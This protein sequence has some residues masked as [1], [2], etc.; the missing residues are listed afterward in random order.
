MRF[1]S[2]F[3]LVHSLLGIYYCVFFVLNPAVLTQTVNPHYEDTSLIFEQ[4]ASFKSYA[5]EV[6]VLLP[7]GFEE[8][9]EA[10]TVMQK[11]FA[12]LPYTDPYLSSGG[13]SLK[14]HYKNTTQ[15]LYE[16]YEEAATFLQHDPSI[17]NKNVNRVFAELIANI[18]SLS[19]RHVAQGMF[20][21]R[22]DDEPVFKVDPCYYWTLSN[23]SRACFSKAHLLPDLM[24]QA[25]IL[26]NDEDA[27]TPIWRTKRDTPSSQELKPY[28]Q[29]IDK[30]HFY[31]KIA[32]TRD[33]D[34]VFGNEGNSYYERIHYVATLP[35]RFANIL[36]LGN[37]TLAKEFLHESTQYL[38]ATAI[39]D[40]RRYLHLVTEAQA[41]RVSRD[42][43]YTPEVEKG[44]TSLNAHMGE[45]YALTLA[46]AS[47]NS[48]VFFPTDV[49]SV[50]G[51]FFLQF[52]LPMNP[53]PKASSVLVP[54]K[55]SFAINNLHRVLTVTPL[56]KDH[57]VL[58]TSP[59][60]ATTLTEMSKRCLL[61][62]GRY[63]CRKEYDTF[64]TSSCAVALYQG[65]VNDILRV[66]LWTVA[67]SFPTVQRLSNSEFV[68]AAPEQTKFTRT[69]PD[70]A[71]PF[72]VPAGVSK[73]NLDTCSA[74]S[75]EDTVLHRFKSSNRTL[76]VKTLPVL[77]LVRAVT[78]NAD[79]D[80]LFD[81][82]QHTPQE[83]APLLDFRT[84]SVASIITPDVDDFV[85]VFLSVMI[86]VFGFIA[87]NC[88]PAFCQ[89]IISRCRRSEPRDRIRSTSTSRR[90]RR[91]QA[92]A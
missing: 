89:C 86:T 31:Q 76:I 62:A 7:L 25:I 49:T 54:V 60:R 5:H 58:T 20:A 69:C 12:L 38:Q 22:D 11:Y 13:K 75:S 36:D 10:V 16:D 44:L 87:Y 50:G 35:D 65:D 29:I 74:I 24:M 71:S 79:I 6:D 78:N 92:D 68:F 72:E 42:L 4:V 59:P 64:H 2:P 19:K 77:D 33:A 46:S 30:S 51:K 41:G 43:L 83:S 47:V 8:A 27:L 18:P 55:T 3:L 88:M 66:C 34:F 45:E 81:A 9:M 57:L 70:N 80:Q 90:R 15:Q 28:N 17:T 39:P 82:L 91:Q 53:T 40:L 14:S 85:T 23:A 61:V 21:F 73:I 32:T 26:F 52:T 84:R 67:S 37:K 56:L 63:Y 1:D 48:L